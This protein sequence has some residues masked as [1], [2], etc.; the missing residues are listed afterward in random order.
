MRYL[1]NSLLSRFSFTATGPKIRYIPWFINFKI[2]RNFFKNSFFPST[3]IEWNKLDPNL[4][5][6]NSFHIYK[7]NILQFIRPTLNSFFNCH[8]PKGIILVTRL[9]TGPSHLREHKFKHSFQDSLNPICNAALISNHVYII[10][11][12][13]PYFKTKDLSSWALLRL[14]IVNCWTIRIS[15]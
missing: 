3:V 7:K 12:T 13:V 9:C 4:L 2:K 14:L 5:N 1:H 6:E 10:F 11:S 8:N 15:A